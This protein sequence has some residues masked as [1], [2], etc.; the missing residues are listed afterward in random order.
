MYL[1]VVASTHPGTDLND[2]FAA[3]ESER[4]R[5][6]RLSQVAIAIPR[7]RLGEVD[8]FRQVLTL[9]EPRRLVSEPQKTGEFSWRLG[10]TDLQ[11]LY[12][13]EDDSV[14]EKATQKLGPHIHHIAFGVE[15]KDGVYELVSLLRQQGVQMVEQPDKALD[16]GRD[17]SVVRSAEGLA[18]AFIHPKT[19]YRTHDDRASEPLRVLI[20][21]NQVPADEPPSSSSESLFS[22][23]A[24][25]Y[26]ATPDPYGMANFF[27]ACFPKLDREIGR[28]SVARAGIPLGSWL[29][30]MYDDHSDSD[31]GRF[32]SVQR[33]GIYGFA[34]GTDDF[35]KAL[36]ERGLHKKLLRAQIFHRALA[37]GAWLSFDPKHTLG[38]RIDI[39][40]L[41]DG[42]F[43]RKLEARKWRQHHGTAGSNP[44]G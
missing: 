13:T 37:Y 12:G 42:I 36:L 44:T 9:P 16:A 15:G 26:L 11:I 22:E 31:L 20:E 25:V 1:K 14:I 43:S 33:G 34:L 4:A 35:F 24:S 5:V 19:T 7:S 40:D 27:E 38:L 6:T 18:A 10:K 41:N 23:V 17:T 29:D 32:L 8:R 39:M 21:L 30:F 3:A 28:E 2:P